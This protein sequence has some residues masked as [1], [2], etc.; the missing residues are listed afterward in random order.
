MRIRL[1]A[2]ACVLCLSAGCSIDRLAG[3]ENPGVLNQ[4][5]VSIEPYLLAETSC[6]WRI[7]PPAKTCERPVPFVNPPVPGFSWPQ[8]LV[9]DPSRWEEAVVRQSVTDNENYGYRV[10]KVLGVLP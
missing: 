1:S 3:P 10:H 9:E 2:A 4:C 6:P 5:I 7:G 8:S